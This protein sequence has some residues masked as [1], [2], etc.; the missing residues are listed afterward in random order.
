MT[1]IVSGAAARA[2]RREWIGL[3]VLALPCM[4]YSMD[5]TV[6][7]LAVPALSADLSPAARSCCGSSTSTA[8]G[9]RLADHHGHARRP[10]RPAPAAADRRRRLR[11]RLGA[12]GVLDQRRD[13]D[14]HARAARHGRRDARA[15]DAVADPQHVPRRAQRTVAIGVWIASYSVGGA[16]GPLVGGVLLEHFW[17]GSVFLLERAGDGAA[18]VLG[19]ILLPEY[20]DPTPAGSTCSARRC[21]SRRC[22]RSSTASSASPRTASGVAAAAGD[23]RRPGVGIAVRAAPAPAGRSADRSRGCSACRAFSASLATYTLAC[24]V[25]VRRLPVHRAVP[26]AG[27][28]PV[29]A[30]G[31]PVD[32]CPGRSPSS[33]AR[34]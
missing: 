32:R 20:R 33:S 18:A 13:A 25:D 27:A 17:W 4:L 10:D 3:A 9:R 6:L 28:R 7:N 31:R 2:T 1:S 8:S 12:G 34:C 30:A 16:I 21:R 23:R 26:A 14:R 5:L 15:I 22:S 19:P 11:R 24:F 29:A